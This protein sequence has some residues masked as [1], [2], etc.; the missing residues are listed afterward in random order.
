MSILKCGCVV[1]LGILASACGSGTSTTGPTPTATTFT[2]TGTVTDSA[3]GSA[4]SGATVS[5]VDGVN[6]GKSATTSSSGSYSVTELQQS[7]FTVGA[8]CSNCVSQSKSVTLTSNQTLSFQLTRPSYA[9]NW[10]GTT[11]QSRIMS[12]VINA[13]NQMTTFAALVATGSCSWGQTFNYPSPLS[14]ASG[15]FTGPNGELTGTFQSATT[16]SGT[17]TV[18]NTSCGTVSGT[19]TATKQ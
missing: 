6:A 12:F 5:I 17:F 3:T 16:A 13:T 15:T 4:I 1:L 9:G 11:S 2:L 10:A 8:S 19:W 14:V 7:G 18:V